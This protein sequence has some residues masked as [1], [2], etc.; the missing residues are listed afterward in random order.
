MEGNNTED[1]RVDPEEDRW[2]ADPHA[3]EDPNAG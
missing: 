3:G 1:N 2:E